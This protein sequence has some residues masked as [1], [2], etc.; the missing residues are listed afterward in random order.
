LRKASAL[1][2]EECEQARQTLA[3]LLVVEV[4]WFADAVSG[5]DDD[6]FVTA[7]ADTCRRALSR[8]PGP[9]HSRFSAVSG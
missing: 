9:R 4:E 5:L 1:L 6:V 7:W 2:G 3:H 8:P